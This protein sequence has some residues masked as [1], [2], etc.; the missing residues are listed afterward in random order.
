MVE[1]HS[2]LYDERRHPWPHVRDAGN[3]RRIDP[4]E[5]MTVLFLTQLLPSSTYPLR[6]QLHQLVHQALL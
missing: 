3:R 2:R 5:R 6:S 1:L 4:V